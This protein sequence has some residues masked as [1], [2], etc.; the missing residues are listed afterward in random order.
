MRFKFFRESQKMI[1]AIGVIMLLGGSVP[2]TAAAAERRTTTTTSNNSTNTW[3]QLAADTKNKSTAFTAV[4]TAIMCIA[5]T[6]LIA[7]CVHE[8]TQRNYS[9]LRGA[10]GKP[11]RRWVDPAQFYEGKRREAEAEEPQSHIWQAMRGKTLRE[12]ARQCDHPDCTNTPYYEHAVSRKR[13]CEKHRRPGMNDVYHKWC[14]VHLLEEE[15]VRAYTA[16]VSQSVRE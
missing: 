7:V 6:I 1:L 11:R 3:F 4:M 8:H 14:S 13:Y 16:L 9:P 5:A 10:N 2:A 15:L 12:E